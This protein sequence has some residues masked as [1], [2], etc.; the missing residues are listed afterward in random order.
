[1]I[2]LCARNLG[3]AYGS[4]WALRDCTVEVPAGAVVAL[5]GPNGAGKSTFLELAVGLLAPSSGEVTLWGQPPRERTELLSRVGFVAQGAPLY[6][7]FRVSDMLTLGRRM[8]PV[9]DDAWAH[10]RMRE[11][12]IPLDQ[13][14][15]ALSGGQ[16]AQVSLALAL[17]KR[18]RLLMLDEPVASLDPLA[19]RGFL[20]VLMEAVAEHDLTVVLSSHLIGDLER[21][22]DF[23]ILL[24]AS[25]VRLAGE[26]EQLVA[27]HK[28][29][30]GPRNTDPQLGGTEIVRAEH[31]ARQ[32]TLIVRLRGQ[33]HDPRWTIQDIG[34][35]ELLLAYM[36][37]NTAFVDRPLAE[38]RRAEVHAV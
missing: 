11:L 1:M 5:V 30:S 27:A 22:C 3:K 35:E 38:T 10:E 17:A 16:R 20:Q 12:E 8:N 4:K 14:A 21:V 33:I 24:T 7:T 25:H 29:L 34:L 37:S 19:R 18:P 2:T 15:G 9:W 32:T 6:P 26:I 13:R 28:V 31:A 23:L 36:G